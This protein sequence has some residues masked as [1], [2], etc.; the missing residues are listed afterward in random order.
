M[1]T[2]V[3]DKHSLSL[4]YN[5]HCLLVNQPDATPRSLPLKFINKI[6]CLHSVNLTTQLLGQLW[7]RGIPFVTLNN[8]YSERSFALNPNQHNQVER[9]CIQYLWQ[10]NQAKSLEI[11]KVFCLHRLRNNLRSIESPS[12]RLKEILQTQLKLMFNC[13]SLDQLRGHEGSAQRSVFSHWRYLLPEQLNFKKRQKRPVKDPVNALLSLTY[14]LV[15]HEAI[16]QCV[17]YGLDAQL[18]FYHRVSFGR[19]SLA[20]D[21]MEPLRPY[22]ENWVFNCFIEGKFN[23]KHFTKPKTP[24][25]VCFLGKQGRSIYYQLIDEEM[26]SWQKKLKSYARWLSRTLDKEL[27]TQPMEEVHFA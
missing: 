4:S 8:R 25:D 19:Y 3:F 15:Y 18:G 21:L 7:E 23:Q 6:I 5:N 1:H 16:R 9:R 27:I 26:Q 22:C 13:E 2:L 10:Q 14:T 24:N 11:A 12:P 20:C 17:A